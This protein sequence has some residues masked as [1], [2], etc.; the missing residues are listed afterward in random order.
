VARF[1]PRNFRRFIAQVRQHGV[2][3]APPETKD[4]LFKAQ[5]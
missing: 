3:K 5:S 4:G 2:A 1:Y